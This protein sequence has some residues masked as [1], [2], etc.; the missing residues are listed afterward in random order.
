M[1]WQASTEP[2]PAMLR[3]GRPCPI[4]GTYLRAEHRNQPGRWRT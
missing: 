3:A 2:Q 1:M 4:S